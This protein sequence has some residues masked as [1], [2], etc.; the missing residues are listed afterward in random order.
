MTSKTIILSAAAACAAMM[1][2]SA[3]AASADP[4]WTHP[5]DG[6]AGY[7]RDDYRGLS[8]G[9]LFQREDRMAERIRNLGYD[10]RFNRWEAARAWRG[11]GDA[12]AET[13]REARAHGR[14]LPADD[15]YRIAARLDGL[16][17]F[18]RHEANDFD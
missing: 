4:W 5:Y 18:I 11:L 9:Q 16:D 1:G 17:R 15:Y 2:L 12:R 8:V 6:R 7:D 14:Y 13:M 3:T 10:G